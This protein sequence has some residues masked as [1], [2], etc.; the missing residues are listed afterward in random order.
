VLPILFISL[1]AWLPSSA[2]SA[3]GA[4]VLLTAALAFNAFTSAGV[5]TYAQTVAPRFAGLLFSIA[6]AFGVL[7]GV[8]RCACTRAYCHLLF[9]FFFFCLS[10]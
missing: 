7:P 10:I 8:V 6:N 3:T 9:F 1:L 5:Q 4:S 2:V